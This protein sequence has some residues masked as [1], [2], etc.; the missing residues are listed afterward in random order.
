MKKAHL[1]DILSYSVFFVTL[2][3]LPVFII[4]FLG[5][6]SSI[7]K[8]FLLFIGVLLSLLFWL[9]ARLFEGVLRFPRSHLTLAFLGLLAVSVLSGVFS[10]SIRTSFIGSGFSLD[11]TLGFAIL[12]ISFFL[13]GVLFTKERLIK[14]YSLLICAFLF[15]FVYQV[16]VLI[17]PS[18]F[19]QGIVEN[20]VG[21]L[22]GTGT[23]LA[24]MSGFSAL[25]CVVTLELVKL[26]LPFRSIVWG[27]FVFSVFYLILTSVHI[28]WAIVGILSFA[29]FV[30]IAI[31]KRGP[32][33]ILVGD[34]RKI[35][36]PKE[37]HFPLVTFL[38][39]TICA[40]FFFGNTL[41]G[42]VV[43]R[44]LNV[45]YDDI[46]PSAHSTVHV[47]KMELRENPFLGAGPNRFFESWVK[48]RPI[49]TYKTL[50]WNVNFTSGVSMFASIVVTLGILGL[51]ALL[52]LLYAFIA[53]L[54][55]TF[56]IQITEKKISFHALSIGLL[57]LYLFLVALLFIPSTVSFAFLCI[58]LGILV[59]FAK[60]KEGEIEISFLKDPRI[61]VFTIL[62]ISISAVLII[63]LVFF[64][65]GKFSGMALYAR[66][67]EVYAR[68]GSNARSEKLFV[69]AHTLNNFD[70]LGRSLTSFY[71]ATLLDSLTRN[72]EEGSYNGNNQRYLS[73]ALI[74]SESALKFN[75]TNYLN[76]LN[77]ANLY[78]RLAPAEVEGAYESAKE[79]FEKAFLYA[80]GHPSVYFA[81]GE[82]EQSIGA[83]EGARSDF[84]SALSIKPNYIDVL[85]AL[86]SL[87]ASENNFVRAIEYATQAIEYA[88]LDVSTYYALGTLYYQDK[89]YSDAIRI[90]DEALLISPAN[91]NIRYVLALAYRESGDKTKAEE[92]LNALLTEN[93]GNVTLI[94][95]LQ[96]INT[97]SVP[98]ELPSEDGISVTE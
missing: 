98:L 36:D 50:Y 47:A 74:A 22:L 78:A 34:G 33:Q 3:A 29:F 67:I 88:P 30:Y 84:E 76:W 97:P 26:S 89:L 72:G 13:A 28:I 59:G 95:S 83:V 24:I 57:S 52:Y 41:L 56:R 94:E 82:L 42:G 16:L 86:S 81:R 61:S 6:P 12:V 58:F 14:W 10:P 1:F 93:P 90:L 45:P 87:Y 69:Q 80:P 75:Q 2:V 91:P 9:L 8:L 66:A 64:I 55:V 77:I 73:S 48:Y 37:L 43:G 85:L 63:S 11:T 25:L 21:G 44:V 19:A 70:E 39:V 96:E 71:V 54:V 68:E 51:G 31:T 40:L 17:A 35:S 20:I 60:Q 49:D 7:S 38:L 65:I 4:P 27:L 5:I 62:G 15:T 18:F 23:E 79:G 32:N 92:I 53:T 46:R